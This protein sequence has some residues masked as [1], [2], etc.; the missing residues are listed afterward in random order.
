MEVSWQRAPRNLCP[1]LDTGERIASSSMQSI[2]IYGSMLN[3]NAM[4]AQGRA[5]DLWGFTL[6]FI[7][8]FRSHVRRSARWTPK[9]VCLNVKSIALRN[10]LCVFLYLQRVEIPHKIK[11]ISFSISDIKEREEH[12]R[13]EKGHK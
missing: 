8:S 1:L 2:K 3:V 11:L 4:V 5:K 9:K 7:Y 13:R 12:M 6:R 10:S